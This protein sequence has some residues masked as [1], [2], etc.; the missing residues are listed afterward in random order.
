MT[1]GQFLESSCNRIGLQLGTFVD[2]TPFTTSKRVSDLRELMILKGYEP[3]SSEILYNGLT[4]EMMEADIFMGP[5]YYQRLKHM[6]EDKINYRSTGPKTLMTHQPVHG[7]SRGGGLAIGEMEK[8]CMNSHGM[9]KFL[10]ESFMDRSDVADIQINRETGILDTSRETMKM[11]YA[12]SL[13]VKELES[14][15]IDIKL[16]TK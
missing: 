4:G 13:F 1:V 11:P 14:S 7:R 8:D 5:V 6:V 3:Y 12:M 16:V 15:H 10:H 2:A 9:S